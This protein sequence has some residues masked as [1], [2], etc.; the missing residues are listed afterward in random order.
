LGGKEKRSL[1]ILTEEGKR[2]LTKVLF[3]SNKPE[4]VHAFL[5][6]VW[7][8]ISHAEFVIG[9]NID[10]IWWH[11]DAIMFDVGATKTD[12]EGLP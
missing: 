3:E 4:H 5:I 7:K 1:G 9:S 12:P 11:G 8:R 10:A 6:L 2:P